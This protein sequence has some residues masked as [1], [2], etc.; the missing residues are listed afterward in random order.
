MFTPPR[1]V[2]SVQT[3]CWF[4]L[5]CHKHI[6]ENIKYKFIKNLDKIGLKNGQRSQIWMGKWLAGELLFYD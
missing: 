4:V 1:V 3:P 5:I 6:F 2:P